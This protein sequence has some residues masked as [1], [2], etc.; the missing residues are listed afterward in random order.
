LK[1]PLEAERQIEQMSASARE[2]VSSLQEII[3]AADPE[4]DSLEGLA[5]HISQYAE[6]FLRAAGIACEVVAPEHIPARQIPAVLRHNLF[7]AVKESLNNAAKHANASR[8]LI[9]MFLRPDEL[10]ILVSDNGGGFAAGTAQN[11]AREKPGRT[12]HGLGNMRERL[13]S[14]GGQCEINSEPGQGTTVRFAVP[15]AAG[16]P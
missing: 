12:G 11:P 9:Q 13:K 1:D 3:W 4:N 10:E 15:L 2:A 14:I 16:A 7:L 5:G 8:V 6:E